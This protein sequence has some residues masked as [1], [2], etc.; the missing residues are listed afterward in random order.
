M[1]QD[2]VAM[3]K[4]VV[5]LVE[6]NDPVGGVWHVK[7]GKYEQFSLWCDASDLARSAVLEDG[8]HNVIED[9]CHLRKKT[10]NTHINV[11]ELDAVLE[12]MNLAVDWGCS[13]LVLHTDSQVV[14]KW[15]N[16][17]LANK[18]VNVSGLHRKLVQRGS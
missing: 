5:D 13:S 14:Y 11:A 17:T 8:A 1:G 15:L 10:D 7:S 18:K 3:C 12:G 4:D 16:S 9:V 6:F 2:V